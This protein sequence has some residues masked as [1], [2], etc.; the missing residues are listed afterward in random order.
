MDDNPASRRNIKLVIAYNGSAYHGWQRQAYGIDTVQ[1]RVEE[2]AGRVIGHPITVFGS[3]RTD[4]GVHAVGQVA[5]FYTDNLSIPLRG[6]R[7]AMNSRLPRDI[8]VRSANVVADDFHASRS[9]V[10]KTYRYRVHVA[11]VRPVELR[12]Q[13]WHYW[14]SLDSERMRAGAV[15]LIGEHDFRGLATSAET[16]E[17][18]V[19]TV[20]R[21]EVAQADS[22]IIVSVTG[23]GFLYNMVRNIVGTLVEIG[24]G[25]WGAERID[26]ILASRDRRD[27]GP[28]APPDGLSLMSVQYPPKGELLGADSAPD[29]PIRKNETSVC[30]FKFE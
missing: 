14:R 30:F 10:A 20:Y 28:T 3:G 4:A 13:V 16:R 6:L 12:S 2:A 11:P 9:A 26:R 5:N 1:Q 7:R 19:R 29:N 24:R 25:R 18:T 15:R 23:G 27:A 21:C 8:T 17:N 22:E